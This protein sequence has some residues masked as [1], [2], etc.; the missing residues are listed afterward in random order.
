MAVVVWLGLPWICTIASASG[1][2]ASSTMPETAAGSGVRL[3]M[4]GLAVGAAV[5]GTGVGETALLGALVG[6][7]AAASPRGTAVVAEAVA[8]A[9]TG[10]DEGWRVSVGSNRRWG[11][12]RQGRRLDGLRAGHQRPKHEECTDENYQY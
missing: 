12:W 7:D 8:E 5:A 10:K 2:L 11:R 9:E 6:A 3:T 4:V 1:P